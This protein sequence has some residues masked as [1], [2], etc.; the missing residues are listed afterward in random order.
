MARISATNSRHWAALTYSSC[1]RTRFRNSSVIFQMKHRAGIKYFHQFYKIVAKIKLAKVLNRKFHSTQSNA[2]SKYTIKEHYHFH[3]DHNIRK[4]SEIN[5]AF[6]LIFLPFVQALCSLLL[7]FS[8]ICFNLLA[9][10]EAKSGTELR[11]DVRTNIDGWTIRLLDA[12]S[13]RFRRG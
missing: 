3:N 6:S 11:I 1:H 10:Q 4:I 2:F 9:K 12:P 7:S 5:L 13:G 8:N